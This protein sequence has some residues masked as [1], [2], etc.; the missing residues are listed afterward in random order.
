MHL[1]KTHAVHFG[2]RDGTLSERVKAIDGLME[3]AGFDHAASRQIMLEMWE[4]WT[5]LATLA[6]ATCLLRGSIGEIGAAPG[7]RDFTMCLL[8]ECRAIAT[9]AGY[10]PTAAFWSARTIC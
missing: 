3:G 2:E 1:N 8:E 9:A 6:G 5:F 7:G 4:K 10:P